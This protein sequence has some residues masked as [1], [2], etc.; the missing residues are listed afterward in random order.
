VSEDPTMTRLLWHRFTL[1]SGPLKRSSDRIQLMARVLLVLAVLTAVPVALAVATATGSHTR[2]VADAEATSR[3]RVTTTLVENAVVPPASYTEKAALTGRAEATWSDATGALRHV[4]VPAPVGTKAGST[5]AVWIDDRGA[6]TTAP[7]GDS[8]VAGQVVLAGL[9]T[10]LGISGAAA[11]GYLAVR[12]LLER[13][14][15]RRWADGWA[16]VEPVWSRKVP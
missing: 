14:R 4:V 16:T 10:F 9:S 15:M 1:G 13:S 7:M 2:S 8:E 6:A 5:V 3:H 12:R 11:L